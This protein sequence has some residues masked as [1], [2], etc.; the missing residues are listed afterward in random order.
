MHEHIHRYGLKGKADFVDLVEVRCWVQQGLPPGGG[1]YVGSKVREYV[2]MTC[3][4]GVFVFA[5]RK[6]IVSQSTNHS[7]VLLAFAASAASMCP[8]F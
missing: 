7:K 3:I 4:I 1:G 8:N 2:H 5:Q 6:C